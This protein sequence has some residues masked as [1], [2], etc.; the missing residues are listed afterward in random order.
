[1]QQQQRDKP[2]VLI[3]DDELAASETMKAFLCKDDYRLESVSTG[4]AAIARMEAGGI[5]VVLCDVMMPGMTGFELCQRLKADQRFRYTPLIL[6]TALDGQDDMVRGIEVGADEFL[7]KP[8]DR[9]VLR[10]RVRAMIRIKAQFEELKVGAPQQKTLEML[11]RDR[12]RLLAD[13]AKLSSREREVLDLLLLGRSDGDI[14]TVLNISSRTARFHQTNLLAKLGSD[15]RV[16]LV[17][18]FL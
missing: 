7:S 11:I 12:V 3:V 1:M 15:S 8:V 5:D 2:A 6:I 4:K 10:A 9:A 17:R 13:D 18:L 16:D 14:S